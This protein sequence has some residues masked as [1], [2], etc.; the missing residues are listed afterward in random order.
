MM[1]KWLRRPIALFFIL[2]LL[3]GSLLTACGDPTA[4]TAPAATTAAPAATT[5]KAATTAAAVTTAAAATTAANTTAA[6]TTAANATT[7]VATTV[8]A[9]TAATTAAATGAAKRGGVAK[10]ALSQ[11]PG[12]LNA[13]FSNSDAADIVS[14][15]VTEGL[16]SPD[17]KGDY[18]PV[19]A[20]E[21]PTQQNGG[22]SAD[23]LTITY[24][25]KKNVKWSD[26]TPF[27]AKDVV[28]TYK[29]IMDDANGLATSG[30]SSMSSVTAQDDNTL[31][32]KYKELYAGYLTR[33]KSILPEHVFAGK[34]AIEKEPFSRNPVG[35]GP[36]KFKNWA[37]GD[38]VTFERN[39]NYREEGKPYLDGV[40]FKITPS[41]E[42]AIQSFQTGEVDA[43][44]NLTEAQ[45][46]QFEKFADAV[47]D[48]APS[49]STERIF[50]NL[51]APSG[52][53]VGD[54]SVPHPILGDLKVR[55]AIQY[56]IDKK[57]IADK[58]L[59]GKTQVANS[60][61]PFGWASTKSQDS[62]YDAKK[63]AQLLDEA[64]W[65]P[66]SDG[67]RSKDGVRMKLTFGTTSGD[68]LRELTQQLIQEQLKGIGIEVEI[69]NV[70]SKVLFG[71]WTDNSA[72]KRGT[73]DMLMW[74]TE[75][76]IDP[77]NHM[78]NYFNSKNIPS[79]ANKGAGANY[80]R[81]KNAEVDAA[82]A[83]ADKTLDQAQRKEAYG[84][85]IKKINEDLPLIL[86]YNRL[87]IDGFKK[88][89][90]GHSPNIWATAWLA[91]N[92]Q[93]WSIEK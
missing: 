43:I 61:I 32:V 35:T 20:A 19:L 50:L 1:T 23:G 6:A 40:I 69:K 13:L 31:V 12:T 10:I 14:A 55:Q 46:P 83:A 92:I 42:T 72:R 78:N 73:F 70:P 56:A 82:L 86:L 8:A 79:D 41:R 33:F 22:V 7:A 51:S 25:L 3:V 90:K 29:V 5:A 52:D 74:T 45:I 84:T 60:V 65:K 2:T 76:D 34:T 27:T 18:S 16:V 93:D 21:V 48:I 57:I 85:V 75:P 24:K 77:A 67:I 89:V 49:V 81:W 30:Y 36:F 53:K 26:G 44:W 64:G 17:P 47:L 38:N 88:Y 58:L 59:Y 15:I 63:A 66:G 62:V 4:T 71:S 80:S 68:K 28:Y 54:P 11:E 87:N 39:T 91:W 9:T 37:S